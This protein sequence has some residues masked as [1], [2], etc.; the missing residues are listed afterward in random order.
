M[1]GE[2]CN[3]YRRHDELRQQAFLGID[4]VQLRS[5]RNGS[6]AIHV[7]VAGDL[8]EPGAARPRMPEVTPGAEGAL[9]GALDEVVGVRRVPAEAAGEGRQVFQI[10]ESERS[11]LLLRQSGS[12]PPREKDPRGPAGVPVPRIFSC[13]TWAGNQ[14]GRFR[15]FSKRGKRHVPP[16]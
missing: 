13:A 8:E 2:P 4:K 10:A 12:C 14:C 16:G 11:E 7:Q 15:V 5:R 3:I 9:E 6:L 1:G